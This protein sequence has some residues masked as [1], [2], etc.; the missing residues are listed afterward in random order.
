MS[1][2]FWDDKAEARINECVADS[3]EDRQERLLQLWAFGLKVFGGVREK[4]VTMCDAGTFRD[5]EGL[6]KQLNPYSA[7]TVEQNARDV[8]QERELL[9]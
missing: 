6:W 8:A 5:I 4:D 7:E 2:M 9:M 1:E 3:L